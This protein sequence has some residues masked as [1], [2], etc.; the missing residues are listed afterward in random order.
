VDGVIFVISFVR[1]DRDGVS[2]RLFRPLTTMLLLDPAREF[3]DLVVGGTSF[4][5]LLS[6]LL[7]RMHDGRVIAAAELL[8][9]LWKRQ[10]CELAAQIHRDLTCGDEHP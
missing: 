7:V 3:R 6:Y 1:T 9:N 4:C 8:P 5:H 2:V 10:I